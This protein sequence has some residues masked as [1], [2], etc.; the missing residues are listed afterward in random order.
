MEKCVFYGISYFA[1]LKTQYPK[2]FSIGTGT[3][4]PL[5]KYFVTRFG[6]GKIYSGEKNNFG[7]YSG[8]PHMPRP[9]RQSDF[10]AKLSDLTSIATR[11][12]GTILSLPYSKNNNNNKYNNNKNNNYNNNNNQ[13]AHFC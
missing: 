6:T 11:T 3:G 2:K 1:L 9:N 7:I 10:L 5:P 12:P 8:I 4:K 13:T